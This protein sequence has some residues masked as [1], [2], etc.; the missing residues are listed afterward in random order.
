MAAANQTNKISI[1][2][3]LYGDDYANHMWSADPYL[4]D[5]TKDTSGFGEGRYVVVRTGQVS[6]TSPSFA[7]A[8]ANQNP[9]SEQ[10]FFVTERTIYTVFSLTGLFL[11][12]A[13]GKPN[14]L[15]KGYDSE[16]RSAMYDFKQMLARASWGDVG[17]MLGTI[18]STVTLASNQLTFRNVAALFGTNPLGKR[19]AFSS[20]TGA[21]ASPPAMRGIAGE[22]TLLTITGVNFSTNTVTTDALLNTVPGITVN[23][24]VFFDGFYAQSMTGK[25]GWNPITA[26]TGGDSFFGIDRSSNVEFL[27]GWRQASSGL[28]EMT[29]ID[30]MTLAAEAGTD[31]LKCYA[32]LRD[33]AALVK[34]VGA[35]YIRDAGDGKQGMGAKGL[36]VYGPNGSCIVVGSNLVPQG[37]AWLGDPS[38]DQLLSEGEIPDILNEDKVGPLLR[39]AD[40]DEYQSRLG[41]YA[42][43]LPND[44]K[45]KLGPGGWVIITW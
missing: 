34:E 25:R 33:W 21:E 18:A 5:I 45:G 1:L 36:E 44:T 2:R 42:N 19:I 8:V 16:A 30:A 27:S 38:C 11:R 6:G 31:T 41:G 9:A 43:F 39:A 29:L 10:R 15:I 14:S 35:K 28:R 40:N 24:N 12:K 7:R 13:K 20:G 23:D 22:P 4:A 32:N 3:R 17:G 37:N 26:P